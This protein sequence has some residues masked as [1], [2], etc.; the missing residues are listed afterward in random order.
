[1]RFFTAILL[2]FAKQQTSSAFTLPKSAKLLTKYESNPATQLRRN[3]DSFTKLNVIVDHDSFT[4]FMDAAASNDALGH[5]LAILADA[6]TAVDVD[7]DVVADAASAVGEVVDQMDVDMSSVAD[8]A[9]EAVEKVGPWGSY[10]NFLKGVLVQIHGI[11][12]A[13]LRAQGFD[14]TWGVSIAVF[15]AGIRALLIPLSVQQTKSSE[16]MKALKPYQND[17]NE[18]FKDNQEMKNRAIA[19]LFEDAGQN[20]LAGCLVSL[21]Q[22]P[23]FLG[24]YR[25]VTGL[26]KDG[27]IDEPFLWIPSLQ[28]PVSPPDYRGMQWLT[29]GWQNI[30]GVFTPQLGWETTLAF[31]VM[32]VVLV[33]GQS[34][35]MKVLSPPEDDNM[36]EEQ[37]EQN[38]KTQQI[39]K[40]LPLL[41]GYFSLQV[42]AGLT[43]Y[44]FTSNLMTVSQSL[45]VRQYYKVNPPVIELPDY[46]DA[47]DNVDNMTPE[48][49][50][51][52]A[53]AGLNTGP[54]YND[55]LDTARY[56][57]IVERNPIRESS[58]A[59]KRV[60]DSSPVPEAMKEWVESGVVAAEVEPVVKV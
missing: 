53:E 39:L 10:L 46:W 59:W 18:K 22:L 15:T 60:S 31:L 17:I 29:E 12:D 26:A 7:M 42:P 27:A 54:S 1:M 47:L 35:T 23:I 56:H 16:Y 19:K 40:F 49:K 14:Q 32:P 45:V 55:L 21:A 6:V 3:S 34:L 28:G 50:R 24:L 51:K 5:A 2:L 11:I 4:T 41:I 37:K 48:E 25:S 20:P 38:D 13:P 33:I 8:V 36:T 58:E 30:D 9:T 44:W 43:I 57:Y 52:A